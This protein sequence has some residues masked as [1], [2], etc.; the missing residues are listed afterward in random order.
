MLS[1]TG[2]GRAETHGGEE[3]ISVEIRS[4]NHRF[5]E[6]SVRLPKSIAVL[7]SRV[8]DRVL[9]RMSRGKITLSVTLTAARK[10]SQISG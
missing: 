6:V 10:R 9:E 4:V 3:A 8:R 7:E 2:Y 5:G 1:M